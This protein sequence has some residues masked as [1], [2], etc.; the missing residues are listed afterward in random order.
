[1]KAHEIRLKTLEDVKNDLLAAEENLRTVRF[2]LVTHQMENTN[3]LG[4]AKR[5]VARLKTVIREHDLGINRLGEP[6]V[7]T[8]GEA[9]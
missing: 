1:M 3:V 9:E 4:R 7:T 8:E 2:Q 6:A 5:E